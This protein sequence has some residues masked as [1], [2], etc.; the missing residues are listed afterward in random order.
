VKIV[1]ITLIA[2]GSTA[3]VKAQD[4]NYWFAQ[5]D[6]T[7]KGMDHELN[8][9]NP[10][11]VLEGIN[12]LLRLEGNRKPGVF[13]GS[14][15]YVSQTFPRASVEVDALFRISELFYGNDDFA[16]SVALVRRDGKSSERKEWYN[17][18]EYVN[19][20]FISYLRWFKRVK[21]IGL[22]EARR[23]KLDPLSGSGISWY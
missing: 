22:E 8:E 10:E 19:K 3:L 20:A 23:Q 11:V 15:A 9:S 14:K 17:R 5:V 4:C 13:G 18:R 16:S 7:V 21:E 1:L 12:C 2:L 6:P